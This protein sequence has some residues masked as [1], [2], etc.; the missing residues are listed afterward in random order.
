M[1]LFKHPLW[2]VGFRPFFTLALLSGALLP[3]IWVAVFAGY[4]PLPRTGLQAVQWHAHEMLFGFGW[5]VLGGFLLTASKNWVKIRGLH[6]GPLAAVVL[7]WIL[8]RFA[9]VLVPADAPEWFRLVALNI[10]LLSVTAYVLW[11]LITYHEQDSFKDNWFF[12]VALPMFLIAKNLMLLPEHFAAGWA[13]S[14]GL[15]RV[16]FCVMFERTMPQFMKN[17]MGILLPRKRFID[18]PIKILILLGAFESFLP[19]QLGAAVLIAAAVLLLWRWFTWSPLRGLS[20]FGI[21]LMY[22]GY[23]G[24][25]AHLVLEAMRIT[26]LYVGVGALSVHVFTFLCMGVVIPGMLIRISQG[27]TGRKLL[28]TVSDRIALGAMFVGCAFRVIATQASP[29]HY[30]WAIT[31]A[32]IG[33]SLCFTLLAFR[34]IPFL[35]QPRIDGREH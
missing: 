17:K 2:L 30:L 3:M 15:F 23:L 8:E 9:V 22:I 12:V 20:D 21:S 14:I 13:M 25:I 31:A 29:A 35:W 18:L 33:W 28:F 1:R 34:L 7:F 19:A 6:G 4:S 32:G 5:A 16:A 27:H 26:G 11:T 10:F 24:L